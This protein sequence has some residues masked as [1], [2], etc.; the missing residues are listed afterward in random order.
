M[1][2]FKHRSHILKSGKLSN[3]SQDN[4]IIKTNNN[5]VSFLNKCT[6][7]KLKMNSSEVCVVDMGGYTDK[8]PSRKDGLPSFGL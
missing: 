8:N 5:R 1:S 4:N 2:D 7:G 6:E 3:V